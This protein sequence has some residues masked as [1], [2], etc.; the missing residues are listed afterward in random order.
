MF[1]TLKNNAEFVTGAPSAR[2]ADFAA[3]EPQVAVGYSLLGEGREFNA[4]QRELAAAEQARDWNKV[5]EL[6]LKLEGLVSEQNKLQG[7]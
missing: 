3:S 2:R 7:M 1:A 5:E 4:I 6:T